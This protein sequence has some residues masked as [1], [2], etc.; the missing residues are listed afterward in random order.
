MKRMGK[1]W[2]QWAAR[3]A[4]ALAVLGWTAAAHAQIG[5]ELAGGLGGPPSMHDHETAF[6]F[7][8]PGGPPAQLVAELEN[9]G[10]EAVNA[11]I[12]ESL[13]DRQMPKLNL[14]TVTVRDVLSSL[15][16][17][18]SLQQEGW[19][20]LEG[21]PAR[22]AIWIFAEQN[23]QGIDPMTG[24]PSQPKP[25]PR[26]RVMVQVFNAAK[27]LSDHSVD[28][29]ATVINRAWKL[30][31]IEGEE[32]P[33]PTLQF[34]EETKLMIVKGTSDQIRL[35]TNIV[36]ELEKTLSGKESAKSNF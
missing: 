28:D 4:A 32:E 12:P 7:S 3:T 30:G 35:A 13:A 10:G 5:A 31:Q 2:I 24:A 15:N 8:F 11:I 25:D 20:W 16:M 34:H 36:S 6:D 23:R 14:R 33:E 19:S 17:L 26:K 27:L 29:L 21:P 22:S 1:Q 9:Q 18:A